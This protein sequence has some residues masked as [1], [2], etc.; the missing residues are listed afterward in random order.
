MAV[1]AC[2]L[3][4][5]APGLLLLLRISVPSCVSP[6]RCPL[7]SSGFGLG[8]AA[9]KREARILL[10]LAVPRASDMLLRGRRLSL[11][12]ALTSGWL[13]GFTDTTLLSFR[14]QGW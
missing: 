4:A 11:V 3:S 2:R 7:A 5:P 9:L 1:T 8:E 13:L 14:P 10:R 12:V 6:R